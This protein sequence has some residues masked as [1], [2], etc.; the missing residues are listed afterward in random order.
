MS[1]WCLREWTPTE[2][3]VLTPRILFLVSMAEWII[4]AMHLLCMVANMEVEAEGHVDLDIL[5]VELLWCHID[6]ATS[7]DDYTNNLVDDLDALE[8]IARVVMLCDSDAEDVGVV[9][10]VD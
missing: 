5:V 6:T 8:D 2:G 7:H 1:T 10:Q 4:L 9:H 3:Q